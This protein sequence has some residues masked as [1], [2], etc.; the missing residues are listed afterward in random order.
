MTT[1]TFGPALRAPIAAAALLAVA[2]CT[3]SGSGD[4]AGSTLRNLLLYGGPTVPPAA[5]VPAIE[6]A[7][8]PSVT[9][10]EGG[11]T[12]RS[13]AGGGEGAAVR[14]QL[15]IADVARECAGRDDGSVVVKVGVQVRALIGPGGGAPRFDT[16]ISFAIK[17]GDTVLASRTARV[18]V[19]VPSGQYEKSEVVVV[20]GLVV[21]AGT[22][23][24]DIEVGLGSGP[25]AA[26]S[27]NRRKRGRG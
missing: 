10:I 11:A 18:S 22:P 12:V 19:T 15:G 4:G 21:P 8:C 3:S 26:A 9:V 14:S 5:A 13:V 27:P 7:D 20:D 17:R 24:Y 23:E 16:P 25:R 1:T 2:G 6:I